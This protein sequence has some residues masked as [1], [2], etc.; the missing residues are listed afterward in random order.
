MDFSGTLFIF[1]F[2]PLAIAG[3]FLIGKLNQKL[4]NLFLI[5]ISLLFYGWTE[6]KGGIVYTLHGNISLYIW[7]DHRKEQIRKASWRIFIGIT[8]SAWLFQINQLHHQ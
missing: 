3:Y 8:G 5:A 6:I 1:Y 2:L 7:K 4:R